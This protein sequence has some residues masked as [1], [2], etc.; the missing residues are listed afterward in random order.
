VKKINK[1]LSF[2]LKKDLNFPCQNASSREP[3]NVIVGKKYENIL[4]STYKIT[5]IYFP[6]FFASLYI[7]D[8]PPC[9]RRRRLEEDPPEPCGGGEGRGCSPES[10]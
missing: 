10:P 5:I 3:E 9:I 1:I 7:T 6:A 4:L 8:P 2:L